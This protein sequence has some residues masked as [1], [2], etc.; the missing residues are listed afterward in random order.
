MFKQKSSSK[1]IKG[2]EALKEIQIKDG[3]TEWVK[4][5]VRLWK[6]RCEPKRTRS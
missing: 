3:N 4:E 6:Q 1:Q 5:S 2:H